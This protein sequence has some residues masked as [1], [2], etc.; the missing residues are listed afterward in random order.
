ML[1]LYATVTEAVSKLKADLSGATAIEY[2]LIAGGIALAI[3]V[4]VGLI[5]DELAALFNDL[6]GDTRC[7]QVGSNCKK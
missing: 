2:A 6:V 1:H 7:I 5:G 4:S 3:L